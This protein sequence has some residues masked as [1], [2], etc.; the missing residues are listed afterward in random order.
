VGGGGLTVNR[1]RDTRATRPWATML[2][3]RVVVGVETDIG[4]DGRGTEIYDR[5]VS[6][7]RINRRRFETDVA[8]ALSET[9]DETDTALSYSTL[10][11]VERVP[12]FSQLFRIQYARV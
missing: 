2:F 7:F 5:T 1:E 10:V 6:F 4:N 12:F 8:R 11:G 3:S 9:G